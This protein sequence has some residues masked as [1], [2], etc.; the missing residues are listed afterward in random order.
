MDHH[1]KADGL[2]CV[3]PRLYLQ[4]ISLGSATTQPSGETWSPMRFAQARRLTAKNAKTH[5]AH[6]VP[7]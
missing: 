3:L 2:V 4:E 7:S 5:L 6:G 1:R